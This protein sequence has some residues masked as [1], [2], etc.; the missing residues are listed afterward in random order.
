MDD[1]TLL[2]HGN[3]LGGRNVAQ[4][5]VCPPRER[6]H[7]DRSPGRDI[8]LRL[9]DRADLAAAH[10]MRQLGGNDLLAHH[11]EIPPAVL[12]VHASSQVEAQNLNLPSRV[13]K[14]CPYNSRLD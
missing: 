5:R 8:E 13:Y 11:Y 6:L 9:E 3:E 7:R 12:A 4:L 2:G 10:G 1:V 14:Q